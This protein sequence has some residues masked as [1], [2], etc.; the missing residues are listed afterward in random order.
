MNFYFVGKIDAN[1]WRHDIVNPGELRSALLSDETME[2]VLDDEELPVI[3][4]AFSSIGY[5]GHNYVGPFFTSCDH[6]CF[7]GQNQH[8][9]GVCS[10]GCCQDDYSEIGIGTRRD[11]VSNLCM[12]EIEDADI[13][14]AWLDGEDAYGSLVEIGYAK[15]FDKLIWIGCKEVN[16]N[17]WFAYS[18]S[19]AFVVAPTAKEAFLT[20]ISNTKERF[21]GKVCPPFVCQDLHECKKTNE[22]E[23]SIRD[24]NDGEFMMGL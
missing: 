13:I 11:I 12:A 20:F 14:F 21:C 23:D 3:K 18:M 2:R 7:H 22:E 4:D 16:Q 6:S 9:A 10:T 8:G 24:E 1:D 17:M 15:A 19:N 5:P